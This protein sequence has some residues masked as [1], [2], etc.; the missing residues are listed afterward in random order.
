MTTQGVLLGL[1]LAR[2]T[3]SVVE[4]A[5]RQRTEKI[6]QRR[7][8]RGP[9]GG[10]GSRDFLAQLLVPTQEVEDEQW[11][12][13]WR[14][15]QFERSTKTIIELPNGRTSKDA[16]DEEDPDRRAWNLDEF[17]APDDLENYT[18]SSEDCDENETPNNNSLTRVH[19]WEGSI[20]R[21][22]QSRDD[23]GTPFFHFT[24]PNRYKNCCPEGSESEPEA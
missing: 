24:A 6:P 9:I 8:R 15:V 23:E 16:E 12:W 20:V 1:D 22:F 3:K 18:T 2:R 17:T 21:M 14:E 13:T 19:P 7:S 5:E 11:S 10:A 4:Q